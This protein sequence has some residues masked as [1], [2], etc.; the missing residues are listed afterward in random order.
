MRH[1]HMT[2]AARKYCDVLYTNNLLLARGGAEE[3]LGP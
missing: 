2:L 1:V 3:G